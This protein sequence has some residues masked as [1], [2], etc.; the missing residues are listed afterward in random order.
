MF[1]IG[2]SLSVP[3]AHLAFDDSGALKDAGQ[4]KALDGVLASLI[5]KAR[6]LRG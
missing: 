2:E 5:G 6:A 1:V 3:Q 4:Q